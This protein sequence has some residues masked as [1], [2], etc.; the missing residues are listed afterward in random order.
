MQ[1]NKRLIPLVSLA[2]ANSMRARI[3]SNPEFQR[4]AVWTVSQKQLLIDTILRGYDIP[5]MY[6]RRISTGPDRF[7]VV[8]GQQRLRTI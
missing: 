1:I 4:P 5:K 6:W 3:D 8:D 2:P 7:E